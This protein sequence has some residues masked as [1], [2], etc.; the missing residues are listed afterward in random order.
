MQR[1]FSCAKRKVK[2]TTASYTID[3]RAVLDMFAM[4]KTVSDTDRNR[5]T[6]NSIC[7]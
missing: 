6:E 1:L 4:R 2:I 7:D 3:L 5:Q